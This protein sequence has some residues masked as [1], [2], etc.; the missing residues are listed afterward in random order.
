MNGIRLKDLPSFVRATEPNIDFVLDVAHKA[1]AII[2]NTFEHD[3]LEGLSTML[4][5]IYILGPLQSVLN[6]TP[7]NH[8]NT[9]GSS[10]W[11]EQHD[12]LS[13]LDSKEPNSV[14]YVN[15]GSITVMTPQQLIE[16]AWGLANSRKTFLWIIR[17]DLVTGDSAIL[18]PDFLN[19]TKERGLLA[20]WCPQEQVLSHPSVGGFLTHCGW[21]ST[22]ESLCICCVGLF[23]FRA[24]DKLLALL[25]RVGY[26]DGDKQ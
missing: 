1:S 18:S 24:T 22:F 15:F 12:C 6:Q 14:V 5:P 20:S 26:R 2:F 16:F 13:C 25:Q 17:P 8:L 19:E 3:V 23:F 4:P 21:N 11:K 10:L 9:I 7:Q